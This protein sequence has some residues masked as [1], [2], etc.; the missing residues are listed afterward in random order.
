MNLAVKM[1]GNLESNPQNLPGLWPAEV[2]ELGDSTDLPNNT[3]VLM[4]VEELQAY[5]ANHVSD[6]NTWKSQYPAIP[7]QEM[8][9]EKIIKAME[10]G[11]KI[12]ADY[13]AT[14]VLMGYNLT[15]VK[16]IMD[17]TA[18]VRDSLLLGSLYVALDEL[19]QIETDDV[20]ITT[21]KITIFRNKI[22][23]YLGIPLT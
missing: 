2:I 11:R 10:F 6:Y 18:K 23:S 20:L 9:S 7:I 3:Y 14:N 16:Y 1:Y 15:Q 13:A 22:Q 5:K 21:A 12:I 8:V 19:S 4:T 17:K